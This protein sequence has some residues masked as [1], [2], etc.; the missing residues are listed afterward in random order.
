M[1]IA[2]GSPNAGGVNVDDLDDATVAIL[3]A[4]FPMQDGANEHAWRV[5]AYNSWLIVTLQSDPFE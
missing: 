2:Y 5:G 3:H 1:T 4:N